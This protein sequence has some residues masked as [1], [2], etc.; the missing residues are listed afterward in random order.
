MGQTRKKR[1]GRGRELGDGRGRVERASSG[2]CGWSEG[3]ETVWDV[4]RW[5]KI[6][7]LRGDVRSEINPA[8]PSSSLSATLGLR[9]DQEE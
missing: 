5:G 3:R 7:S 4:P 9:K 2:M 8:R 1:V 6:I